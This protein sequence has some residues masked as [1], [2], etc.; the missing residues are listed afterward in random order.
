[1]GVDQR[2]ETFDLD[3]AA[4]DTQLVEAEATQVIGAGR[5]ERTKS[6]VT[7]R[8]GRRS[9]TL[10]TKAGDIEIGIPKLRR[11]ASFPDLGT[12]APDRPGSSP[13]QHHDHNELGG[14]GTG[15]VP[16]V[17][18]RFQS[19]PVKPCM[20]FSRTRLTDVLH[21]RCSAFPCQSRKGRGGMTVRW[22]LA[23]PR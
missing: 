8:N 14:S 5:D 23:R 10:A 6:R 22:R 18:A 16:L 9:E 3:L 12:P 4:V 19:P 2:A 17:A 13:R 21:R 7:E 1:M 20:R 11:A 15:A